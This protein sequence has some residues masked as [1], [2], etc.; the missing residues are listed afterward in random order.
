MQQVTRND[1]EHELEGLLAQIRAHPERA[2][3]EER[4]R[5]AVLQRMLAAEHHP[6]HQPEHRAA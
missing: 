2:W 6:E 4:K 5:V 3:S 1:R